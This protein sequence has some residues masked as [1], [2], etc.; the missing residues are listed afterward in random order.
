MKLQTFFT[1]VLFVALICSAQEEDY[2]SFAA[3]TCNLPENLGYSGMLTIVFKNINSFSYFCQIKEKYL[4]IT[5]KVIICINSKTKLSCASPNVRCSLISL[6]S[7][8]L[9]AN[10]WYV[11][12][13]Q[14][15]QS[16]YLLF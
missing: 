13:K 8:L 15:F 6:T 3:N 14:S 12:V 16:C 7:L 11:V 1:F 4:R 5:F 10:L 2:E 9:G